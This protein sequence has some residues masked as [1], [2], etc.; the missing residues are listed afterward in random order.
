MGHSVPKIQFQS[1]FIK[2][3]HHFTTN[4]II[5][6][7]AAGCETNFVRDVRCD[8]HVTRCTTAYLTHLLYV[9]LPKYRQAYEL[10]YEYAVSYVWQ[11]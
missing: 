7:P 10:F 8:E 6:F 9:C 11:Q 3:N 2:I 4:F 5:S 1:V